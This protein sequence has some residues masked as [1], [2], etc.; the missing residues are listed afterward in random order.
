MRYHNTITTTLFPPET[1]IYNSYHAAN[2]KSPGAI[3]RIESVCTVADDVSGEAGQKRNVQ[4][5]CLAI[6]GFK[7]GAE[8]RITTITAPEQGTI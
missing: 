5:P 3:L 7:T 4:M 6:P 1:A 2:R 8:G